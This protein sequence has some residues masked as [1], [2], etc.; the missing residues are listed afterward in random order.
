[1]AQVKNLLEKNGRRDGEREGAALILA[2]RQLL[3]EVRF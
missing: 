3:F 2:A 1:M